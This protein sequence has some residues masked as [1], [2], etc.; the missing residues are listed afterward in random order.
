MKSHIENIERISMIIDQYRSGTMS[1]V[2]AL[3]RIANTKHV[4][5]MAAWLSLTDFGN[6]PK[7]NG[8]F[9]DRPIMEYVKF[10]KDRKK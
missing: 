3:E 5:R 9:F 4:K 6:Q 2:H 1:A 7:F 8:M 10:L